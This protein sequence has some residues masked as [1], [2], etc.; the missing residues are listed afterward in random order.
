M[1]VEH[2]D[3]PA[4]PVYVN[5]DGTECYPW[6][7]HTD[8]PAVMAWNAAE[9]VYQQNAEYEDVTPAMMHVWMDNPH[10]MYA[11]H[12]YPP[13][14]DPPGPLPSYLAD[15]SVQ[16]TLDDAFGSE[17]ADPVFEVLYE[18]FARMEEGVLEFNGEPPDLPTG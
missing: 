16:D 9:L 13:P 5:D 11:A 1:F 17:E 6:H 3:E 14:S 10:G 7:P 18:L 8:A 2:P 15:T 12:D 4:P